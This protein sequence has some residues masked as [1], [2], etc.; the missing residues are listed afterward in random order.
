MITDMLVKGVKFR[1]VTQVYQVGL[2]C[3][4]YKEGDSM[5]SQLNLDEDETKFHEKVRTGKFFKSRAQK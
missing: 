4:I 2:Y 5:P 3:A 1:V